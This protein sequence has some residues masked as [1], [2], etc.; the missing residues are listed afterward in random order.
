MKMMNR[1]KTKPSLP[2]LP[3]IKHTALSAGELALVR[4]SVSVCT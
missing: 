4:K 3:R 2:A 1:N